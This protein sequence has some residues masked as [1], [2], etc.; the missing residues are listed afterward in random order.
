MIFQTLY[1]ESKKKSDLEISAGLSTKNDDDG[2]DNEGDND[3]SGFEGDDDDTSDNLN[4]NY[5]RET[6]PRKGM[7]RNASDVTP[8]SSPTKKVCITCLFSKDIS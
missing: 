7:K 3:N 5:S 4:G 6:T 8:E 1:T 2:S